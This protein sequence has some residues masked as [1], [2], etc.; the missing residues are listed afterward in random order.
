M[1]IGAKEADVMIRLQDKEIDQ[2][3]KSAGT[4]VELTESQKRVRIEVTLQGK[5]L[6]D[7]NIFE[8]RNL[9]RFSFAKLQGRFFQFMLPTFPVHTIIDVS[10]LEAARRYLDGCRAKGFLKSGMLGLDVMD[11]QRKISTDQ[12]RKSM[13]QADS[14]RRLTNKKLRGGTGCNRDYV[15]YDE[16]NRCVAT[17]LRHLEQREASAWRR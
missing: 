11:A 16:M 12:I 9:K 15:A 3:N 7:N 8:L 10:S 2:Q 6:L 5:A 1:Y 4:C 17:A 13:K 14:G